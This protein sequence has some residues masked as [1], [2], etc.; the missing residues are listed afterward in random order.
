MATVNFS[1]PD[2]VKKAFDKAFKGSNKSAVIAELMR[3]AVADRERQRRRADA[4]QAIRELAKQ[5]PPLTDEEIRE[6]RDA[7]RP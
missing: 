3:Q 5:I 6:A 2:E 4:V 7:G 1:V